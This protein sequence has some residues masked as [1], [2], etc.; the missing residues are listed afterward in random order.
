[1]KAITEGGQS[2]IECTC[3]VDSQPCPEATPS[4]PPPNCAF[5][6]GDLNGDGVV[7]VLDLIT[8]SNFVLG[9]GELPEQALCAADVDSSGV[10]DVGVS[11]AHTDNR[12][13]S[14]IAFQLFN[15]G[16]VVRRQDSVAIIADIVN[17]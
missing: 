5:T 9:L 12:K 3:F 13:H 10:I 7:T 1:M 11:A 16:S 14:R 6:P 15:S 17:D 8:T 4:P 2:V